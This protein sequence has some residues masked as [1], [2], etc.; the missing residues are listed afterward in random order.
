M[1]AK[2]ITFYV[3]IIV[4]FSGI[5]QKSYWTISGNIVQEKKTPVSS[6]SV[7]INNTSIG[8]FSDVNGSF[9]LDIPNKFSQ[10]EL[11]I[12]AVGYKTLKRKINYSPEIQ[13]FKFQ[14]ENAEALNEA[15]VSTI[16]DKDW[17]KKWKTF[18]DAI[19]GDS[20]FS[21]ECKII[22]PSVINLNYSHDKKVIAN[23]KGP[24]LIKNTALG[25]TIYFMMDK[26]ESDGKNANVSGLKFFEKN[27]PDSEINRIK[28]EKNRKDIFSD[29]FRSFLMALTL[30]KSDVSNF[31]IFRITTLKNKTNTQTTVA[32]ELKD[33]T[34]VS[35]NDSEIYSFDKDSESFFL[36]SELP[37]LVF[38]KKRFQGKPQYT[39]YPF[40]YSEILLPKGNAGFNENGLLNKPKD[41]ILKGYWGSNGFSNLL[42]EDYNTEGLIKEKNE[43][44][45]VNKND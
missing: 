24:I 35:V 42:P 10:I 12:Y 8:A 28:W 43:E 5:C 27:V 15:G 37:L 40:Q 17:S 14:L 32:K 31:E 45:A 1:K 16:D 29:S 38:V 20:K 44:T 33:G 11:S 7:F 6:A 3:L 34:L 2:F 19:V 18:E 36:H 26:F 25:Y 13:I 9:K 21:K 22:N 39:D 4:S 30:N 41:I 23:A